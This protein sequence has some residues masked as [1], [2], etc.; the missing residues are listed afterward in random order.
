MQSKGF[1]L[2]LASV[3]V[4]STAATI[5]LPHWSGSLYVLVVVGYLFRGGWRHSL[6]AGIVVALVWLVAALSWDLPN[7]GLLSEKVA[8]LFGVSR[9][10]L[11]LITS[12][13]GFIL[14]F[15]GIALGQVLAQILPQ[16]PIRLREN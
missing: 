9:S 8:K 1:L 12:L 4:L 13:I 5:W 15:L 7:E 16:K 14:G 11:W 10:A 2:F 6:A 3:A